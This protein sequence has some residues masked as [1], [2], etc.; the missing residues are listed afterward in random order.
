MNDKTNKNPFTPIVNFFT[1]FNVV[2]FIVVVASGLI[3]AILIINGI[4]QS[5]YK[6]TDNI[7]NNGQTTFD[8]STIVQLDKLK[9]SDQNTADQALPTGR[10][11]PFI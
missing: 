7:I 3:A 5:P 6:T 8:K 11:N 9:T 4:L 1:R 2:I 10:I